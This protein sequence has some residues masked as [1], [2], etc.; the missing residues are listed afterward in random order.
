VTGAGGSSGAR[1]GDVSEHGGAMD[2]SEH[3][4]R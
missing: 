4:R 3:T 2:P 1:F